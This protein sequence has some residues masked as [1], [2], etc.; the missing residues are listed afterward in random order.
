MNSCFHRI[1]ALSIFLVS[2]AAAQQS[3]PLSADP[4]IKDASRF[5]P[6]R[7]LTQELQTN[8]PDGFRMVAVG[9]CIISRPL[10]QYAD[11]DPLFLKTVNMLKQADVTYGNLETSIVDLRE[12]K[13]FPFTASDDFPLVAVPGVARDLAS[14]GFDVMS[15][16]NNHSFDWGTEG[17]RET[18][19]WVDKAGIVYAGVGESQ[20]SARAAHYYE[21][22]KGRVA[23]VSM[24]SSFRATTEALPEFAGAPGRPGVSAL[25]VTKTVMVPADVMGELKSLAAKLY[26]NVP[27]AQK[28]SDPKK[29]ETITLFG[30]K[31]ELGTKRGLQHEMN[32]TEVGQILRAI[33]QGKQHSDFLVASIHSHETADTT[34]PDP[35]TDFE[36]Q[37]ADFLQPL[38][39]A[40]ID[41]GADAFFTTG[42]HHLGPIEIYKGRPIFYG[43]GNFFWSDIQEPMPADF[44]SIYHDSLENAFVHPERATDADFA[45]ALNADAFNGELP[46]ESLIFESR[47]DHGSLAEVRLYP[48]DLGY[49]R[50][51]TESGIPR[52]AS[53][54]KALKILKRLQAISAP[55]GTKIAIEPSAEWNYVGIIRP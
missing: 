2:V 16:A 31:F 4:G 47:F 10:S 15:R 5:D 38:A 7:P 25:H 19:S 39:R 35:K 46:F 54:E 11:R 43:L 34:A 14:M 51:L 12:F 9:D 55:Y 50:K 42:I 29:V 24:A 21:S 40:A 18:S 27:V 52:V 41:S 1:V 53:S 45:N 6:K 20:G 36:D 8:V 30:T 17:M 13:G 22:S 49:G 23:I 28:T 33:R 44:Y 32:G 3:A 37:P 26:P 48:V